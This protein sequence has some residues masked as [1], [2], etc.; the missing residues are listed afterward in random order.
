MID[1]NGQRCT[2]DA[3]ELS[4]GPCI[5][6]YLEDTYNC[7]SYLLMADKRRPFCQKEAMAKIVNTLEA[8][9]I[10]SEARIFNK[11]GCLPHC[12][13]DEIMLEDTPEGRSWKQRKNPTLA[14]L[15][16]F[17]DGSYQLEEEYNVYDFDD[18]IAD[19]GGF[20]GLLLGHSVLSMCHMSAEWLTYT[21]I[22]RSLFRR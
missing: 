22:W 18:F 7:T 6:R 12:E 13:R 19:V 5:T 21:K 9:Q 11:T 15:F 20:L 4:P 14:M 3:A 16:I 1:R 2:N 10:M 8:F 17:E